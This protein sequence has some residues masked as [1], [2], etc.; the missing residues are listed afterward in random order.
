MSA[1][2]KVPL[3]GLIAGVLAGLALRGSGLLRGRDADAAAMEESDRDGYET[4]DVNVADT[5]KV[6]AALALSAMTAIGIMVWLMGSFS[7]G[8]RR[9][10][11]ALTPQQTARLTPP[12]PNL[13]PAPYADLDR[14]RADA[15]ARLSGYG[16]TDPDRTRARIP[17]ARAMELTVGR[18]L[19]PA[20]GTAP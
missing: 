3:P 17:I 13:Q 2:G 4:A 16:Y 8:Q 1:D 5:V 12:A 20:D 6:M 10:L 9:A 18:P 14:A 19:D 15:D 11:P 7:A